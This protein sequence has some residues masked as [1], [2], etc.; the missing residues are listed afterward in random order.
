MMTAKMM[1]VPLKTYPENMRV[2]ASGYE[3]GWNDLIPEQISIIPIAFNTG[4]SD[5][6]GQHLDEDGFHAAFRETLT[7]GKVLTLRRTSN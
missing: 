1:I 7:I 2:V 3:Q 6:D 4:E 5:L